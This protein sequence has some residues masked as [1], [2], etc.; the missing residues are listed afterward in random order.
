MAPRKKDF[1]NQLPIALDLGSGAGNRAIPHTDRHRSHWTAHPTTGSDR[2][3]V[4]GGLP[5]P[6]DRAGST[7]WHD[8]LYRV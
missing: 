6:P 7:V 4:S 5:C 1:A 8:G 3:A 2:T